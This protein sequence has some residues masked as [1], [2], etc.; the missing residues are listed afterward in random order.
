MKDINKIID[1]L[2]K[3]DKI[4]LQEAMIKHINT[5]KDKIYRQLFS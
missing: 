3:H 1:S 2:K 5:S 4:A